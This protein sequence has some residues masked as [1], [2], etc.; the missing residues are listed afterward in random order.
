MLQS[1][2][3]EIFFFSSWGAHKYLAEFHSLCYYMIR[4]RNTDRETRKGET[5]PMKRLFAFLLLAAMLLTMLPTA[6]AVN[7]EPEETTENIPEGVQVQFLT[8][9]K[10]YGRSGS[11]YVMLSFASNGSNVIWSPD[12]IHLALLNAFGEILL[13]AVHSQ[14]HCISGKLFAAAKEQLYALYWESTRLTDYIYESVELDGMYIRARRT[15]GSLDFF[16]LNGKKVTLPRVPTG[17]VLSDLVGDQVAIISRR[18]DRLTIEGKPKYEYTLCDWNGNLLTQATAS[19]VEKVYHSEKF[20]RF[21]NQGYVNLQGEPILSKSIMAYGVSPSGEEFLFESYAD[22]GSAF[23]VLDSDLNMLCS[24]NAEEA[25]FLTDDLLLIKDLNG[26][27]VVRDCAGKELLRSKGDYAQMGQVEY[28]NVGEPD[29]WGF[30]IK[31]GQDYTLYDL[32]LQPIVTRSGLRNAAIVDEYF[33]TYEDGKAVSYYDRNGTFLFSKE[34]YADFACIDGVLLE[35]KN[36]RYAVCDRKG[37]PI[38]G[39]VYDEPME[40]RAYGLLCANKQSANGYYLFNAAGEEFN[41]SPLPTWLTFDP[42]SGNLTAYLAKNGKKGIL[43]YVGPDDPYYLDT[44]ASAWYFS[45]VEYCAEKGLVNGTA[46]GRFEPEATMT[47]AM[48]VTVLWR[49]EGEPAPAAPGTFSDVESGTWYTDAVAWASSEGIVNGIGKGR[50]DPDGNVTREQIATILLRYAA[51]KGC[52][53]DKRAELSKYPDADK[54]SAY[55]EEAVS[56]A[57]AEGI[58]GGSNEN[59]TL[60]LLPQGNA[61]RA[62]VAAMLMRYVQ[63]IAQR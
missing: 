50:F 28:P 49:L 25:C 8:S 6:Y 15:D 13:P 29:R 21:G 59:G 16:Y 2:K 18:T 39:Y 10:F 11:G 61:T 26:E 17:W 7:T 48:L 32:N 53:G 19:N 36:N 43:R 12:G 51:K 62:Q 63:N 55:A 20:L 33:V 1:T 31:N 24:F 35:R 40:T 5:K 41:Q 58:I 56:W 4:I 38:T 60:Y 46:V 23:D 47:R 57:N 37:E 45:A 27:F 34:D 22:K 44:P 30:Y 52:A 42:A 3:N 14:L 9:A 54:V